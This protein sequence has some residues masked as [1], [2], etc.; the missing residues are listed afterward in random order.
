MSSQSQELTLRQVLFLVI[1]LLVA[2]GVALAAVVYAPALSVT[3]RDLEVGAVAVQD[4]IAPTAI[5][6]AS[7]VLTAQK[8]AD[9]ANAVALRYT[10]PDTNI[11]RQQLERLRAALAYV[12]SVRADVYATHEQKLSDLAALQYITL[13]AQDADQIIALSDPRWQVVKQEAIV[14]LEQVMRE[15]IREDRVDEQRERVLNRVSLSLNEDQARL[16]ATLVS[17]FIAPNSF[18]S[19]S[20]TEAARQRAADAVEP[21]IVSYAAGENVV[22]RGEVITEAQMEALRHLGL[23]QPRYRWQELASAAIMILLSAGV[24][25]LLFRRNPN[26]STICAGWWC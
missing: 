1:V 6:Y 15:T 23:A 10:Q 11:A 18:Y 12:D 25:L 24:T 9:A 22:L 26:T 14:V 20:L 21:E 7:E 8:R 16:V 5:S 19:E 3:V 2:S 17:A 13:T 4:I